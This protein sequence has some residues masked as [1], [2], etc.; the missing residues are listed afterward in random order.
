MAQVSATELARADQDHLLHPL[1]HPSEHAEPMIWVKGDGPVLIDVHGRE[2]IDG[3]AGLWN[4]NAGHGRQELAEAAAAQMAE[5]AY[6]SGY[7]GSASVPTIRLAERLTRLAYPNIRAVFFTSGGAESNESA[8]KTARWYWKA[9]GKADKVKIISRKLGYHGVTIGAMSA[10]GMAAYHKWFDPLAP[11]FVQTES[12]YPYRLE[13]VR[14]G[15]TVGQAAARMLEE[16]IL[17]E[18]PDTVAAFIAEPVQGAGGV[19]VPPDDYFPRVR[20]ICTR[21]QILFIADE[22]ITG[23]GRTGRWF[24]LGRWNVLP[25]ILSFAKGVT[26]GYL[27]LGGI[28]VSGEI[29]EAMK[30]VAPENRWM[31]AY[32]YSGHPT[33][34]AVGLKNLEL[35]E[36]EALPDRA[37]KLGQRLLD[38]LRTLYDLAAVGD[39]RGLGLMAAVELV[40][41]RASKRSFDPAKKVGDRINLAMRRRGVFTRNRNEVFMFAPPLV[42]TEAQVDRIVAVL[43]ESIQEVVPGTA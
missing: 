43:R 10:T 21:H 25:D 9:K 12:P 36:R 23:F 31:H 19:I 17:R 28:M 11:G 15:E 32:T 37:A 35:M 6:A 38:G 2:F 22:V 1:Y 27:P 30:T 39:V 3:L 13:G 18:G 8:F 26:S 20:E 14:P 42:I 33:C 34:C 5:L 40:E 16:T 7:T 41:D 24:A 4:V 29:H